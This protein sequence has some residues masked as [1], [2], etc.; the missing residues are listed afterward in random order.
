[1]EE[2]QIKSINV[3][4]ETVD[5]TNLVKLGTESSFVRIQRPRMKEQMP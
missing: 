4:Q 3:E 2:L 5:G 1:M